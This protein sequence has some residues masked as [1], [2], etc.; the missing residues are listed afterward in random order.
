MRPPRQIGWVISVEDWAL[1][2]RLVAD[3]VPQ[4]QVARELGIGRSTV[5][6]AVASGSPPKYERAPVPTSFAP[7]EGRVRVLRR[8]DKPVVLHLESCEH[9][10]HTSSVHELKHV[11]YL[12]LLIHAQSLQT[13]EDPRDLVPGQ[14]PH[15]P[16]R[17]RRR[18]ALDIPLR[19][20]QT[21]TWTGAVG[22]HRDH[23]RLLELQSGRPGLRC[24]ELHRQ[25]VIWRRT[26]LG[27]MMVAAVSPRIVRRISPPSGSW[28]L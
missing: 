22:G 3:G 1:I 6:R 5:A 11:V 24:G 26:R 25:L 9:L 7:F 20:R 28:G 23:D 18:Q 27:R 2:R 13:G 10:A 17:H 12:G 14:P 8:G 15:S 19:L 4:R 21:C 16:G